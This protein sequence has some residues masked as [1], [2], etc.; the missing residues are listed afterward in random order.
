MLNDNVEQA[1]DFHWKIQMKYHYLF[2]EPLTASE[3]EKDIVEKERKRTQDARTA[4]IAGLPDVWNRDKVIKQSWVSQDL[5]REGLHELSVSCLDA[6][7]IFGYEY[8]G[9]SQR[10]VITPLTDKCFRTMFM[11]VHY[12][13]GAAPQGPVGTGKTE[14]T[15]ELAKSVGKMCFV[16]NC[17]SSLNYDSLLKF[18]KGFSSG[19][20]WSCFDEFNRIDLS[21]LSVISQIIIT[22]NTACRE[23]KRSICLD[24]DDQ[25]PFDSS[26][27]IF[28]TMN[29]FHQGRSKLPDNLKA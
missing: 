27:S 17:S 16:F 4:K 14:T 20:S 12:G 6:R 3:A 19:G 8:M 13:Y 28:I 18:F 25:L 24:G 21:V 29:P 2:H 1:E 5:R 15:K 9:N 26:C 10:L 7:L 11:A 23:K 22:I